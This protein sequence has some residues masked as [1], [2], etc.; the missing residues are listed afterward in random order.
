MRR[1]CVELSLPPLARLR[2]G[3][4]VARSWNESAMTIPSLEDQPV[5]PDRK[6]ICE[7]CG[8]TALTFVTRER[9]TLCVRC[10]D[11]IDAYRESHAD[12]R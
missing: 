11:S 6:P 8:S 1:V 3:A 9:A 7:A 5:T 4:V 12:D 2:Y 10:A